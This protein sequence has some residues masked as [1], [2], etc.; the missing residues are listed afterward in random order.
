MRVIYDPK[1]ITF[2][3]E[4]IEVLYTKDYFGF[5][6]SAI[7]YVVELVNDIDGTIHRRPKKKAPEHFSKYG[8]NMFYVSYKKNEWTHWY[9]FFNLEDD[10]Y[11]VRYISNNHAIAQYL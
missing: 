8:K 3:T 10:I 9:I 5:K 6:D 2:L 4:L 11:Y 1:V 7:D